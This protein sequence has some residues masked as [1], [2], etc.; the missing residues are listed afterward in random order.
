MTTTAEKLVAQTTNASGHYDERDQNG[1]G[2]GGDS[3]E[4]TLVVE[5]TSPA[6]ISPKAW[7]VRPRP[8]WQVFRRTRWSTD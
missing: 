5:A 6:R 8:P 2:D 3:D 1:A 7:S 4:A